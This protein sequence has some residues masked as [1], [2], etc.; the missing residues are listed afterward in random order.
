[1][2]HLCTADETEVI[3][4]INPQIVGGCTLFVA[5]FPPGMSKEDRWHAMERAFSPFGL[6]HRIQLPVSETLP[7]A[8]VT[9]YS[10]LSAA[11]AKATLNEVLNV[12]KKLLR[13]SQLS[14]MKCMRNIIIDTVYTG[15]VC[16]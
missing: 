8:F 14:Q 12:N 3:R 6:L 2:A 5:G 15:S 7:Y 4:F 16:S 9:F 1:M 11:R 13:V 10:N